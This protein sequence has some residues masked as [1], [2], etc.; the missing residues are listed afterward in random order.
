MQVVY[1][2]KSI[3]LASP[4]ICLKTNNNTNRDEFCKVVSADVFL[5]VQNYYT[6][7]QNPLKYSNRTYNDD[8]LASV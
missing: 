1:R 3:S 6:V 5:T 2:M 7:P 8:Q 4:I